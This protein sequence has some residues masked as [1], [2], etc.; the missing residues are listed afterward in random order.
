MIRGFIRE[1]EHE[2]AYYKD[3]LQPLSWS[4]PQI[5]S[6]PVF[7]QDFKGRARHPGMLPKGQERGPL[8]PRD[9]FAWV[10][11][12]FKSV[13][14]MRTWLS[15]LQFDL[16]KTPIPRAAVQR[17]RRFFSWGLV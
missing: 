5:K 17:F 6:P 10:L 15:A 13:R 9:P 11:E 16:G 1:L 8:S 2:A 14:N 7:R 3:R 4:H 12:I